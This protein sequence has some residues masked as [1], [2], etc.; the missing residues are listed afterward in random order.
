[1]LLLLVEVGT[2]WVWVF[3]LTFDRARDV[4]G[5]GGTTIDPA[6]TRGAEEGAGV[7]TLLEA[8]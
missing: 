5:A 1:M 6:N 3:A 4:D 8:G 7:D 2:W